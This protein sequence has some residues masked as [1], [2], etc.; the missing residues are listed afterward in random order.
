MANA[1]G[2]WNL[3]TTVPRDV[4]LLFAHI[5]DDQ[6]TWLASGV[7]PEHAYHEI[8]D[9]LHDTLTVTRPTIATHWMPLDA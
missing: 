4:R 9:C 3:I 7:F 2:K 5:Q 8:L 6:L 1:E